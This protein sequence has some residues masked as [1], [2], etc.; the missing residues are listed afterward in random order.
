MNKNIKKGDKVI[1]LS[2]SDK[3]TIGNVIAI[4]KEDNRVVVE[5]VNIRTKHVKPSQN[6]EKGEIV[7]KEAAIHISNVALYDEK[8]KKGSRISFSGNG[9]SKVRILKKSNK[10][11]SVGK[12]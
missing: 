12:K 7:K 8:T 6:K 5:G 1:V 2:G 10:E 11:L 3:G 9:K 4:N